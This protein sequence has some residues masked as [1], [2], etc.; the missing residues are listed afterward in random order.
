[1]SQT[2]TVDE[3]KRILKQSRLAENK[4]DI[5]TFLENGNDAEL[6]NACARFV[7]NYRNKSKSKSS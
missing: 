2:Y 3:A 6:V 5:A 4:T 1:M 7:Q